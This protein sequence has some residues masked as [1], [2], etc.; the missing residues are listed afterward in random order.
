MTADDP[1]FGRSF[2]RIWP[3]SDLHLEIRNLEGPLDIQDADVCVIAGD[4]SRPLT[5]AIHWLAH[6]IAPYMPVVYVPGNHEYYRSSIREG[7]QDGIAAAKRAGIHLLMDDVVVVGGVRFLGAI[8]WTDYEIMGQKP[9]AMFNA[10]RGMNDHRLIAL[11]SRPYQ[12]FLPEDALTMHEN[13]RAFL[14]SALR[15]PFSGPT[16][17][18]THHCPHPLSIHPKYAHDLLTAAF[19]SDLSDL[20]EIGEP[21]LWIHGHT[22]TS[23][24]YKVGKTRIVCNP[25]G[26]GRENKSFDIEKIIEL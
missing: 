17:V 2:L 18:V 6:E 3:L 20:I 7:N 12:R 8:L 1:R 26:Y 13:S 23:F 16:V 4:L 25:R 24:D 9:L 21:D 15:I 19:V 10:A 22:H 14:T 11:Q 5:E